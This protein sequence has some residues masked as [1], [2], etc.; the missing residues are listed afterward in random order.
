MH[1]SEPLFP[2]TQN[3]HDLSPLTIFP[4]KQ[5]ATFADYYTS[6]YNV[7]L[8]TVD[9]PLLDVDFTVLRL[10]LIVP[11]YLNPR[12]HSLPT[13]NEAKRQERLESVRHKQLLIP[14]LCYRH[15]FPASVWRKAV[16][17]PSIIYRV[18]HLLLAEEL[19]QWIARDTGLGS[20]LPPLPQAAEE[21]VFPPL[22]FIFPVELTGQIH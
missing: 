19:R 14:E 8:S 3:R 17:L 5:F 15:A 22:R 20:A 18:E 16:C 21:L 4:S 2:L 1:Y 7:N 9:Q 11:R 6:K 10:C 12:G 13:T